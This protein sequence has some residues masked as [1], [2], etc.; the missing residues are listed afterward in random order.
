MSMAAKLNNLVDEMSRA[1]LQMESL[2]DVL[3]QSAND[4]QELGAS[5]SP[6]SCSPSWSPA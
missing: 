4:L 6:P 3:A 1:N 5:D 2:V